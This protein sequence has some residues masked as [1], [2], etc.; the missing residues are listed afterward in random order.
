MLG[1]PRSKPT[2]GRIRSPPR[3]SMLRRAG[4]HREEDTGPR[5]PGREE[6]QCFDRPV[7]RSIGDSD[8]ERAR[9]DAR[10]VP[11]RDGLAAGSR[12]RG[13]RRRDDRR[14][15]S[16]RRPVART[17]RPRRDRH[18]RQGPRDAGLNARSG[19]RRAAPAAARARSDAAGA[20]FAAGPDWP[21]RRRRAATRGRR[22]THPGAVRPGGLAWRPSRATRRPHRE[23]T[24]GRARADPRPRL[25]DL[26]G[27]R[28]LGPAAPDVNPPA[29]ETRPRRLVRRA[30]D[31]AP[32]RGAPA[33]AR[34][35]GRALRLG[36]D[37]PRRPLGSSAPR[38][39]RDT[40]AYAREVLD[41]IL[42]RLAER[43]LPPRMST[44]R[45]WPSSTRTCTARRSP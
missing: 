45:G 38:P 13:K 1:A 22:R 34:R 39:P 30:L 36:R 7:G 24:A 21:H 28:W 25:D 35:R 33:P 5:G 9:A 8:R 41:R 43:G 23:W 14:D 42:A 26:D 15:R 12:G 20:R 3:G 17:T 29:W 4:T 31:A 19:V 32:R 11:C 18:A 6:N 44:S 16:S 10:N 40:F 2:P 27:D 37:P